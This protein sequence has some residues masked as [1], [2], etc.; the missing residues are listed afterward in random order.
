MS[1]RPDS[2]PALFTRAFI[3]A[4][5]AVGAIAVAPFARRVMDMR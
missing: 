4:A 2:V 5:Q 1:K 3:L